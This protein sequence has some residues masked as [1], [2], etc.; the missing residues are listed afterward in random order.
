MSSLRSADLYSSVDSPGHQNPISTRHMGRSTPVLQRPAEP[1]TSDVRL[2]A[3]RPSAP[4]RRQRQLQSTLSRQNTPL[5][6][7]PPH[8]TASTSTPAP[9]S[10]NSTLPR[11][12][13]TATPILSDPFQFFHL[14]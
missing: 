10:Q 8:Q 5:D 13:L 11:S 3:A 7:T 9:S 1:S 4:L 6:V 2:A 12:W 14:N